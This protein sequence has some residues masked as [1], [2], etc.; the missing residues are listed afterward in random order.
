MSEMRTEQKLS[1]FDKVAA[2]VLVVAFLL[3]GP[4]ILAGY[5][6]LMSEAFFGAWP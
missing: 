2:V 6:M 1:A 3:L 4:I 5:M